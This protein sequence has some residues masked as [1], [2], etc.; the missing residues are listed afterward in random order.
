MLHTDHQQ[1]CVSSLSSRPAPHQLDR[2][3]K[4]LKKELGRLQYGSVFIVPLRQAVV[5]V[6]IVF[7]TITHRHDIQQS[8][9]LQ[10]SQSL[11]KHTLY[12]LIR[13]KER[14]VEN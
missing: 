11:K 3:F 7:I 4:H 8:A 5:V 2:P 6:V 13:E 14:F 1:L 9:L 10:R 12:Y